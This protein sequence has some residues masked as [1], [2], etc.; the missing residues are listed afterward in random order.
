VIGVIGCS[1]YGKGATVTG[2]LD[3]RLTLT[4]PVESGTGGAGC[5]RCIAKES[6]SQ[7]LTKGDSEQRW[8]WDDFPETQLRPEFAATAFVDILVAARKLE[9]LDDRGLI[10]EIANLDFPL[11]D[12]L[13][14][15]PLQ[16]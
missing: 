2:A 16:R 3:D 14:H 5:W 13:T 7:C 9:R 8:S 1:R 15:L 6:G 12:L 4:L 11:S 10:F